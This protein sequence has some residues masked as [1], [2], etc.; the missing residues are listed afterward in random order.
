VKS[1]SF[2][3]FHPSIFLPSPVFFFGFSLLPFMVLYLHQTFDVSLFPPEGPPLF[4]NFPIFY[5][6]LDPALPLFFFSNQTGL[7][8]LFPRHCRFFFLSVTVM[9]F[10]RFFFFLRWPSLGLFQRGLEGTLTV[11]CPH[12]FVAQT[13][14]ISLS[15]TFSFPPS[16]DFHLCFN[17]SFPTSPPLRFGQLV[18]FLFPRLSYL[19]L[20]PNPIP[21][22]LRLCRFLPWSFFLTKVLFFPASRSLCPSLALYNLSP[23]LSPFPSAFFAV[24]FVDMKFH[25]RPASMFLVSSQSSCFSFFFG[26][27]PRPLGVN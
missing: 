5:P 7:M 15:I 23:F 9:L 24:T 6:S 18:L 10:P 21:R 11:F 26:S 8:K 1:N 2:L 27:P 13:S 20:P 16:Q 22:H 14:C 17:F 3:V 19:V 4:V 12:F 25:H